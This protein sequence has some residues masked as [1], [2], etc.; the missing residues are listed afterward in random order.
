MEVLTALRPERIEMAYVEGD[1]VGRVAWELR[2]VPQGTMAA[3]AYRGVQAMHPQ[4]AATFARCGSTLHS[5]A[6]QVDALAG[7][8]QD[9][10]GE[11]P[12]GRRRSDVLARVA[13]EIKGLHEGD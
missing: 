1:L 7:L 10:V 2:P 13:A 12:D 8:R 9:V 3:Y 6:M 4:S 11:E 5:V